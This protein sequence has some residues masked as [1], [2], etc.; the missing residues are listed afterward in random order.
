MIYAD[1]AVDK[2]EGAILAHSQQVRTRKLKKGHTLSASDIDALREAGIDHIAAFRLEPGD[3][4]EDDAADRLANACKGHGLRKSTAFTGRCNLFAEADGVVVFDRDRL[5]ALNLI[6]ESLTL[7]T[8]P[9]YA[10]V[11]EGQLV[12][13]IKIIPFAVSGGLLDQAIDSLSNVPLV[14]V[15]PYRGIDA[16]LIE[17]T[18]PAGAGKATEKLIRITS[19]RMD[20]I[21]GALI[22]TS[23]AAHQV[24]ALTDEIT[25][26]IQAGCD[27][28][29][30]A[31]ASANTDRRDVVPAAIGAAGGTIDHFGMPVDPGNLLLLAHIGETP[32]IGL[33]G[34][35]RSPKL[36]GFDWV[37]QRIGAEL[38]VT[39]EDVMRM[40]AGG[41]LK[42][43]GSRPLPRRQATGEAKP[44]ARAPRIAAI[45]MAAGTSSRMGGRN[46]LLEE[47]E[48][49][50]M[51]RHTVE[52]TL[53]STAGPVIV[54]TGRDQ[55]DI[56]SALEG[57]EI[58]FVHNPDFADGM[59][60][61]LHAGLN[62]LPDDV[63]GVAICL[64]DMPLV[65]A[66]DINRLIAA[67]DEEEGRTICV[68]TRAGKWGNPVLW[69]RLYFEEMQN[70]KGD[71]GARGLLHTYADKICEVDIDGDRI[72]RDF[73]TPDAF[74]SL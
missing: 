59:A 30:I 22:R 63:D 26:Q 15:A 50:P 12:G 38:E 68:P 24:S 23:H 54:V 43:I 35:A 39:R 29:L 20:E 36:N 13:T 58:Q 44:M 32:V 40:G 46:K 14:S 10:A 19:A 48:G 1:M 71:K 11:R 74:G 28:L 49:A 41:L 51:I 3:V 42:E 62:A 72:F 6:D 33:P 37:L 56:Q 67:F 17:T 31:G 60:G 2:A 53:G 66:A 61:S 70:I 55:G 52:N 4:T 7:A 8:L 5:D 16:A 69:S 25:R 47:I 18:L 64:G 45:V 65:T 57:L 9:P 34:C 73:D 21:G 27:L